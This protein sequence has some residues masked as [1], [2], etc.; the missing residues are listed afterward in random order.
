MDNFK[1]HATSY[2]LTSLLALVW[3]SYIWIIQAVFL[4]SYENADICGAPQVRVAGQ[5]RCGLQHGLPLLPAR[6]A[7]VSR[8]VTRVL[9]D[10]DTWPV[11][12]AGSRAT[13]TASRSCCSTGS[14]PATKSTSTS[15]SRNSMS[16][17][18]WW[19]W[20]C[21][22]FYCLQKYWLSYLVEIWEAF[23]NS[24]NDLIVGMRTCG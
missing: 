1:N 9:L 11:P 19:H 15:A 20:L 2:P 17:L 12:R 21:Q 14:P 4:L 18:P 7:D 8:E 16:P 10:W 13:A 5:L 24:L 23:K 3:G 6:R 22:I